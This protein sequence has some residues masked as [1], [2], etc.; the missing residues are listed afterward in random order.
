[1]FA[2]A[3][4]S[5]SSLSLWFARPS[6]PNMSIRSSAFGQSAVKNDYLWEAA[7][8]QETQGVSILCPRNQ[9]RVQAANPED[10]GVA[11]ILNQ[12]AA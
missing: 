3:L 7:H 4:S 12:G 2:Q 9:M 8:Q 11:T 1:M 5:S 10:G 6:V